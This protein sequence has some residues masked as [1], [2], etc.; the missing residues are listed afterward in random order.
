MRWHWVC[1]SRLKWTSIN[2]N[3]ITRGN[4]VK[5]ARGEKAR[6][7]LEELEWGAPRERRG[8]TEPVSW[9]ARQKQPHMSSWICTLS[10][11]CWELLKVFTGSVSMT[12]DTFYRWVNEPEIGGHSVSS[13]KATPRKEHWADH[14]TRLQSH[15]P[16]LTGSHDPFHE[17]K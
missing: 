15:I 13:R 2:R 9:G 1:H 11:K 5:Q 6:Q 3:W 4:A 10:C 16:P 8:V 7:W 14:Q 12:M 17:M